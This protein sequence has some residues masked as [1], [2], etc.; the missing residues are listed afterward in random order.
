ML[1]S[2]PLASEPADAA[3][4]TEPYSCKIGRSYNPQ[5][6]SIVI[7]A[8][9][10][11]VLGG[12]N[13]D[14]QLPPASMTKMMTAL[15]I[16]EALR[17]GRLDLNQRVT[18]QLTPEIWATRGESNS[19][20]LNNGTR[21]TVREA[22]AAITT[23]SANNVAAIMATEIAGSEAEFVRM[24][25]ER[26]R[27]IGMSRTNFT[28]SHGLPDRAQL[29]TARDMAT[30]AQYLQKEF[31]EYYVFFSLRRAE[32]GPYRGSRARPNYNELVTHNRDIDGLK[33]GFICDSGYNVAVSGVE[34]NRRVIAVV[35]GGRTPYQRNVAARNLI[36][37]GLKYLAELESLG[38]LGPLPRPV[39]PQEKGPG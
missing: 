4:N 2:S 5:P 29:S 34:G 21:L 17:D 24:M 10:G 9:T 15:L 12:R 6:S 39:V 27:S 33:T 8:E 3:R 28:N 38:T 20:W 14:Q 19:T 11:T 32:F 7:D 30:L 25:N 18:V 37:E 16:F 1:A 23:A 13:I 31:P 35:F 26:A 22:L 36:E